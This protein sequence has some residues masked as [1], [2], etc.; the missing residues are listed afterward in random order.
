MI[1]FL[2]TRRNNFPIRNLLRTRGKHLVGRVEIINY[3]EILRLKNIQKGLFIFSDFDFL[4]TRQRETTVE[5]F[6]SFKDNYPD[7]PLIND[8]AKSLLRYDLLSLAKRNGINNFSVYRGDEDMEPVRF[9][10]FIREADRHSGAL[11]PLINSM[12]Q[13]KFQLKRFELLGF[14]LSELLVIEFVDTSDHEGNYVKYSAFRLG[15]CILPRYLN[16]SRNWHV[17]SMIDRNDPLMKERHDRIHDYMFTNPHQEWLEKVFTMANIEY[18]RAD[19]SIVNGK[20][21]LWE[22]NLN[23]AFVRPPRKV[24]KDNDQQRYMRDAFYKQFFRQIDTMDFQSSGRV[25]LDITQ[26]QSSILRRPFLRRVREGYQARL[27]KDKPRY[28]VM[29]AISEAIIGQRLRN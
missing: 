26:K 8:P 23:P 4:D 1:Y 25:K 12:D 24:S 15:D 18:G 10:V 14:Q 11:T 2:L 6:R 21:Q 20:L 13:L 17:K 19:Y 22:I 5:I 27:F 28:R 3:E 16:F 7:V 9:P 29:R